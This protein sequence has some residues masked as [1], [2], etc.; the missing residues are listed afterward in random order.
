MSQSTGRT[1]RP[2]IT[3]LGGIN[4]DLV[5]NVDHLPSPG[6]SQ[7]ATAYATFAGGKGANQAVACAKLGASVSFVSA[8]GDDSFNSRLRAEMEQA[9]V[10]MT[11]VLT[12]AGFPSGTAMIMVDEQGENLISFSPGAAVQLSVEDIEVALK[13]AGDRSVFLTQFELGS[14]LVFPA[15]SLAK[16]RG[17]TV[18]WNPA[19]APTQPIPPEVIQ[20]VDVIIPNETEVETLTGKAI[21][22]ID[23]A[24]VAA[25][26]LLTM[27]FAHVIVTLG[28]MGLVS[29]GA[30]GCEYLKALNVETVDTTAAGDVFVGALASQLAAGCEMSQAV[31][32]ANSAAA[33][34]TT[35]SGTMRS[36]PALSDVLAIWNHQ[37]QE[38]A[39][40]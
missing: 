40:Q 10:D 36:I 4:L 2:E 22:S 11:H 3:V 27:G 21:K 23:D 31:S 14:D 17:L 19:P 13:V 18:I 24:H 32:F 6:E 16:K 28:K 7:R 15:L 34:S 1:V 12:K 39:S 20:S 29:C 37:E 35:A 8:L 5:M 38:G 30:N 25:H 33:L 26:T 9:D